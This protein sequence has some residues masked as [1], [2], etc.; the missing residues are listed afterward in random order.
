M[1]HDELKKMVEDTHR[2]VQK[3]YK[4]EK[5]RRFFQALKTI[6]IIA[7]IVGAYYTILPVFN[8]LLDSYNQLS[9][10]ISDIKNIS[11][12]WSKSE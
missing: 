7:I 2:M 8:S 10:Q 4:F 11:F 12:P 5:R 6:I 3:L 1:E 9:E